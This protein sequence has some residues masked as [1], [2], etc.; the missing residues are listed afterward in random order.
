MKKELLLFASFLA[1]IACKQTGGTFNIQGNRQ[2][3][4]TED[5]TSLIRN[6][7]MGWGLYDDATG[8]VQQADAYWAAQDEAATKYASFFYVRWRWSD[9]EP[10]EGKYAWVHDENYRKL[11]QGALDRGLKLCFRVFDN[12]QDMIQPGTPDFVRQAGAK[13]YTVKGIGGKDFWN[14]YSD[15][16]VFQEKLTRFVEAFA[17]EYDNPDI[18]DFID[19]YN[20]G[21]WGEAHN[22]VL[23]DETKR[24]AVL[25]WYTALYASNFKKI[26]LTMCLNQTG[27]G[28]PVEQRIVF[29]GKGYG[30]RRDGLGSMWFGETERNFTEQIYGERLLVGEAC[31]WGSSDDNSVSWINRDTRFRLST[32]RDVYD[33]TYQDAMNHHFNTLD[34]REVPETQGWTGK[35][36]DLVE[37]FMIKGGYRLY[38]SKLSLPKQLKGGE[39]AIIG[40]SWQN[41]ANGYLPN[42]MPNWNYKYKPAFALIDANGEVVRYWVDE[43]AEPSD[44]LVGKNYPYLLSIT[45]E[46]IPAGKYQWAAAIVDRTKNDTPGIRL[47]IK[48]ARFVNQWVLLASV[49]VK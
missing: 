15:D 29:D 14:P 38:P 18:V 16:P 41:T 37:S 2:V 39:E 19:G 4:I 43:E 21:W 40:H 47:A 25:D 46:G 28:I 34:L 23:Q 24:E 8:E 20:L 36:K 5:T 32:W 30:I 7:C 33:A 42:N 11:I 9:M 48:E 35:A 3:F 17:K 31:Y 45:P 10:E 6:P 12:G 13:G 26:I 49:S 1:C 22:V 27:M 44:W